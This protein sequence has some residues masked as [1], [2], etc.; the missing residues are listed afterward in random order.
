MEAEQ[1]PPQS[2]FERALIFA[3]RKHRVQRRKGTDIPYISHLMQVAGL[4]QENGADEDAAIA[5]LLHDVMEDQD[6]TEAELVE[7]FGPQ[8]AAIVAGCSD[9]ASTEKAP[10]RE[11]K[12]AYLAHLVDASPSRPASFLLRQAAQRPRHPGRPPGAGRG[13]VGALQRGSGRDPVVLPLARSRAPGGGGASRGAAQ[14][15]RGGT[16]PRR[17]RAG[18][19]RGGDI[20]GIS[21]S[22]IAM[23]VFPVDRKKGRQPVTRRQ[24]TGARTRP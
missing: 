1:E 6:V 8:V 17:R 15:G 4:A 13:A 2:R 10:W 18:R 11:R 14:P 12:E 16:R 5:A 22:I 3:V 19:P 21:P 9:S 20:F 23:T 24:G 7:R